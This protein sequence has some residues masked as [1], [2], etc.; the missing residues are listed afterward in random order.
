V[1]GENEYAKVRGKGF[2]ETANDLDK[3]E[4]SAIKTTRPPSLSNASRGTTR[5]VKGYS[6]SV[7]DD[8]RE[9]R[10]LQELKMKKFSYLAAAAAIAGLALT[11]A[12]LSAGPLATG[13]ATGNAPIPQVDEGLVKKVHGWHCRWRYGHR[14]RRACYDDDY[15]YGYGYPGYGLGVVPFF[16][17]SFDDDDDHHHGHKH[18]KRRHGSHKY[19]KK[20]RHGGHKNY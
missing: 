9:G 5:L 14:H 12:P 11:A 2:A 16:S 7:E 20:R 4:S 10:Q 15:G 18:F 17:F 3:D 1:S 19:Y 13:L 8:A 6:T